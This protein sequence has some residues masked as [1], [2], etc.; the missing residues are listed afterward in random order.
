MTNDDHKNW[1]ELCNRAIAASDA[2]ELLR[3]IEQLNA[4]L[5]REEKLRLTQNRCSDRLGLTSTVVRNR[6]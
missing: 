4:E 3:I 6:D 5:E 1:R 2:D